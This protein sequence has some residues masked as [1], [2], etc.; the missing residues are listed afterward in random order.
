MIRSEKEMQH[1]RKDHRVAFLLESIS[2]TLFTSETSTL[3]T[4]IVLSVWTNPP[5]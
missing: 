2:V 3:G 5:I 4:S 1:M